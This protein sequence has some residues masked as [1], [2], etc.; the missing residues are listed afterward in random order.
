MESGDYSASAWDSPQQWWGGL[1][2]V[3]VGVGGMCCSWRGSE[4]KE[5]EVGNGNLMGSRRGRRELHS[6]GPHRDT[7]HP[8]P[9]PGRSSSRGQG[10]VAHRPSG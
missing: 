1:A 7:V 10:Q 4:E 2:G 8:A 5:G 9:V 6:L 3:C